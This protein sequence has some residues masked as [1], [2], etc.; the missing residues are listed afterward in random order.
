MTCDSR[1]SVGLPD[2]RPESLNFGL[3]AD[4]AGCSTPLNPFSTY[5]PFRTTSDS[6][7]CCSKNS[8]ADTDVSLCAALALGGNRGFCLGLSYR[9]R[10]CDYGLAGYGCDLELTAELSETLAHTTHANAGFTSGGYF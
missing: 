8:T 4:Y 7:K 2:K 10:C 6:S 9:E 5:F 3:F 1:S